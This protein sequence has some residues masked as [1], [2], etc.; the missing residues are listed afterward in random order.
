MTYPDT[1]S[2]T[3]WIGTTDN[4]VEDKIVDGYIKI[5][6]KLGQRVDTCTFTIEAPVTAPA[7]WDEVVVLDG[8]TRLF[9][10]YITSIDKYRDRQKSFNLMYKITASDYSVLFEKVI[11]KAQYENKTDQYIIQDIIAGSTQL[12]GFTYGEFVAAVETWDRVRFNRDSLFAVMDMLADAAHGNWYVDYDKRVRFFVSEDL[13]APFELSDNPDLLTSFP[14]NDL[15]A[16]IDGSGV[17]NRVEIVGGDALSDNETKYLAGTGQIN[18][19]ILPFRYS[20]PTT[21]TSVQIYRNDGTEGSPS[22]TAMTVKVG[23][24]ESL[25]STDEVLYYFQE[26]VI[27]QIDNWPNLPNAVKLTGRYEYPIRLRRTAEPS[28]SHYG[29]YLDAVIKDDSI[30]SLTDANI[31]ASAALAKNSL[32]T[33]AYTCTTMQPGLR[34]GQL[35]RLV[36]AL[37]SIDAYYLI[38]R[39]TTEIMNGGFSITDLE[40]GI[41]SKDLIDIILK[42]IRVSSPQIPWRDDEVLDEILDAVDDTVTGAEVTSVDLTYIYNWAPDATPLIWSF[43]RWGP[44][45]YGA[46]YITTEGGIELITENSDPIVTQATSTT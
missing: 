12:T 29:K 17:F 18:R 33:T 14:Y 39:A 24:I 34:A 43:G 37:H 19:I 10:G 20:A 3:V 31:V 2:L 8:S 6:S 25:A 15:T 40:L 32:A 1:V 4:T 5:A 45:T 36:N 22:W 23:Y 27:E 41:Y 16:E 9:A 30:N 26:K 44:G 35:V 42:L 28:F 13:S 46:Y 21:D 11:V 7:D 38:H